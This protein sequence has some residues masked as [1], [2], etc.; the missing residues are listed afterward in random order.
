MVWKSIGSCHDYLEQNLFVYF[1]LFQNHG[2]VILSEYPSHFHNHKTFVIFRA[3]LEIF[4]EISVVI[5][6]FSCNIRKRH[7]V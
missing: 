2:R 6:Y 3:V 4:W 5:Y 1:F 7:K